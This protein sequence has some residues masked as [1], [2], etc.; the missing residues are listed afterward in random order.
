MI[1]DGSLA[2]D[3]WDHCFFLFIFLFQG[4]QNDAKKIISFAAMIF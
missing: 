1:F 4:P 3:H 2:I